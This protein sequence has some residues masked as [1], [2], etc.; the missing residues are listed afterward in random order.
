MQVILLTYLKFMAGKIVVIIIVLTLAILAW[1][2]LLLNLNI[3]TKDT[4][5]LLSVIV[6]K[7]ITKK[8]V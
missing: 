7:A 5:D 4:T 8:I 2:N 3:N 1:V 6:T